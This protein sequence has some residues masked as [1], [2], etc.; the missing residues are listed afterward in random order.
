MKKIIGILAV[1]AMATS[2]FAADIAA[3]VQ[4]ESDLFSFNTDT[5]AVSVFGKLE[6]KADPDVKFSVT[7][8]NAGASF[9]M[10]HDEKGDIT[11]MNIWFK[12][13]DS[14][15]FSF[16]ENGLSLASDKVH[17]WD[18]YKKVNVGAGYGVE[19]TMDSMTFALN[20][21]PT[22][23]SKVKDQDAAIGEIGAKF[24]YNA[25]FGSIAVIADFNGNFKKMNFGASYANNF[26]G[27]NLVVNAGV[28]LN[29]GLQGVI[30]LVYGGYNMDA[31]SFHALC[32]VYYRTDDAKAADGVEGNTEVAAVAKVGYQL[33]SVKLTAFFDCDNLL[34][35]TY[36]RNWTATDKAA[37][38]IG[39]EA[40]GNVG[41]ASWTVAPQYNIYNDT[42]SVHFTT[43]VSY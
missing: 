38:K 1:A 20:A 27:L 8:D 28:L 25:D 34:F 14:L 23:V 7:T 16:L 3:K 41:I 13:M 12:P 43:T 11:A 21:V 26:N 4:L 2:M 42:L 10:R 29:E 30:G 24:G 22:F 36:S 33:D 6:N 40:A 37:M 35:K 18:Y 31:L 32:N 5:S 17:Y 19:Y 15:K 39:V 9:R